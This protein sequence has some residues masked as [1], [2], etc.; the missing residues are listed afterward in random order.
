MAAWRK[1]KCPSM[2]DLTGGKMMEGETDLVFGSITDETLIA[3]KGD[4][5]R[6]GSLYEP[7]QTCP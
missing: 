7:C 6:S 2:L 5:R 1:A 3:G 4:V